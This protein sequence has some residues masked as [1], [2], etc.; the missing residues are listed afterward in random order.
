MHITDQ[1]NE[2]IA[3]HGNARD[4]LNVTLSKLKAAEDRIAV[5]ESMLRELE[6]KPP[7]DTD[8]KLA[9]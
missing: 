3:Y 6:D 1:L 8:A 7:L 2:L 5:L 9:A 4:A